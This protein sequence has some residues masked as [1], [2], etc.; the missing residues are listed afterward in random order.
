MASAD[1]KYNLNKKFNNKDRDEFMTFKGDLKS[2][3]LL[4]PR[5]LHTVLFSGTLHPSVKR[6][7]VKDLADEKV[8]EASAAIARLV[9]S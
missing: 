6:A 8:T 9:K 2:L 1:R 3:L 5:K 4:H 7:L